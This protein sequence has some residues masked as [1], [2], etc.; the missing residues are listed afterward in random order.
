MSDLN[1]TDIIKLIAVATEPLNFVGVNFQYVDLHGLSLWRA[2]FTYANLTGADLT[3]VNLTEAEL[4]G[5]FLVEANLTDAD[6]TDAVLIGADLTDAVLIG[7][8]LTGADLT[9]AILTGADLT[10]AILQ[11][12]ILKGTIGCNIKQSNLRKQLNRQKEYN[13][14]INTI[15]ELNIEELLLLFIEAKTGSQKDIDRLPISYLETVEGLG[16]MLN[17]FYADRVIKNLFK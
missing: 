9:D 11:D 16:D 6:L 15:R 10:G 3:R 1:K 2:N 4:K 14:L 7:A 12:T 5:A 13:K 17:K 8:D